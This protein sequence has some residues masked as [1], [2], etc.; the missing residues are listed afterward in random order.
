MSL[1]SHHV[2]L[3]Q[4]HHGNASGLISALLVMQTL[5]RNTIQLIT[6]KHGFYTSI[7]GDFYADHEYVH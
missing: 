4:D 6:Q 1:N 2:L 7:D 5:T 3:N